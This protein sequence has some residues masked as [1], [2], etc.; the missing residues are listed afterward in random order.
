MK[1]ED[2]IVAFVALG[3]E[4]NKFLLRESNINDNNSLGVAIAHAEAAN[5]W[6][7]KANI[8][9][10]LAG[11][12][13]LL[14]ES[15]LTAWANKY[16]Y[17]KQPKKV[18]CVLAGNIPL[19][20]FHDMLCVLLSGHSF[21]GKL[22][23][24]D[25]R[26]LP[27]LC[28]ILQKIDSNFQTAI[29]FVDNLQGIDY[30]AVIATGSNNSARYFQQYFGH[31]PHII[32]RGRSSV[33]ILKGNETDK[34]LGGLADDI[35]MY[36]GL[37]CRNISKIYIPQDFDICKI[38]PHFEKYAHYGNHS[39][40]TNNYEYNRSIFLLNQDDFYE[41]GFAL[42]KESKALLSPI[43]VIYYESYDSFS[44]IVASLQSNGEQLQCIVADENGK[45]FIPL[46]EA[47][48][49]QVDDYADGVD[50]MAFLQQI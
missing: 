18:A 1:R 11:I 25:S 35:F 24:K 50:T 31:K 8:R 32:R 19:V 43:A 13:V 20:G 36:F 49:P 17:A 47:Q 3:K 27:V 14:E 29:C 16:S 30:D 33:A 44:E 41:T 5:P 7:T 10:A 40:W 48:Y 15:R 9:S 28:D 39:K 38:F 12:V 22:S 26:L 4:V 6:F 46:G 23:S 34:Q 45:D 21:V 42:F 37:G 2:R